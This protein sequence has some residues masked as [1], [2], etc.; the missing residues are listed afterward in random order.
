MV[1]VL[2]AF[3]G[4]E[5]GARLARMRCEIH[6]EFRRDAPWQAGQ[7]GELLSKFTDRD[8]TARWFAV[9]AMTS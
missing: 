2:K 8:G 5:R 4:D 9:T 1:S 6:P 7:A 3:P